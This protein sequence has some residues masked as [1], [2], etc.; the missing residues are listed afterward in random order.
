M[1]YRYLGNKTRLADWIADIVA[2]H[3][4]VGRIADPMCGT[5]AMSATFA[6]RGYR[7]VAGDVLRFPVLHAQARLLPK[8]PERF[9]PF[10]LSYSE[11][12]A[13]LNAV[14]PRAGFFAREYGE[15]GAPANGAR[16][17]G[18]FTASNA[19]RIDAMRA[20]IREWRAA[21]L[22]PLAADLLLHD[23]ILAANR[24]ANIAGTYG[25]YRATFSPASVAQIQLEPTVA[26]VIGGAHRVRQGPAE[27]T[28]KGLSV[29]AVYL[30]PPY[31]KRQYGGNYHIPETIAQEDTPEPAGEGG[32]REWAP[33]AFCYSRRAAGAFRTVMQQIQARYVFVSYSE[34]AHLPTAELTALLR[35][36]GVVKRHERPT[37]RY[38]SN[39]RVARQGS[40]R[41]H[42]YVVEMDYA[43]AAQPSRGLVATTQS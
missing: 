1:S 24:V 19:E 17:R 11:A 36:Y 27:S 13:Y 3:V 14:T 10:G 31:T 18:Y 6:R 16:A 30:D 12:I 32:L 41:E 22:D 38:R 26:D 21:G 29:D 42:L 34:D 8:T 37:D 25:F 35:G 2:A 23:L 4:P 28:L 40:V 9:A 43:R 39:D 7:V 20:T 33:S 15:G 5:G